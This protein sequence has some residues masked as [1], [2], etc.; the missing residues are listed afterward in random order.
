M[1]IN[2]E[3]CGIEFDA[4]R[5]SARF[6]TEKCKKAFRRE[7]ER[8]AIGPAEKI[9]QVLPTKL[10]DAKLPDEVYSGKYGK[11]SKYVDKRLEVLNQLIL[12]I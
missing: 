11:G 6:D 2:C 12:N 8:I 4:E 7:K 3:Y 10:E 1:K 5:S 9:V